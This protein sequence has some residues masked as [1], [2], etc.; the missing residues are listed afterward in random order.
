MASSRKRSSPKRAPGEG[1]TRNP[2][3]GKPRERKPLG[4]NVS[5]TIADVSVSDTVHSRAREADNAAKRVQF[6]Y[7]LMARN[8]WRSG[9]TDRELAEAWGV[10]RATVWGYSTQASRLV[11][12]Q[13]GDGEEM[14]ERLAGQMLAVAQAAV[15]RTEEVATA[16]GDVVKV[17]KPDMRTA[18]SAL[19]EIRDTF[20]L[21]V[22]K[23]EHK[24][25]YD[26]KPLPELLREA[27]EYLRGLPAAAEPQNDKES[28]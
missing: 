9:N 12:M 16:F 27:E 19:A 28:A 15:E 1:K 26:G 6:C 8:E 14:R 3:N 11:K 7:D 25:Q 4:G 23:H 21:K 10:A 17:R 20:G 2:S 13:L 24:H 22:Q 5:R 18:L